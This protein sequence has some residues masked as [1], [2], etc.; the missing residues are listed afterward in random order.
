MSIIFPP[1]YMSVSL[2][3]RLWPCLT[4]ALS[5]ATLHV[6]CDP[7]HLRNKEEAQYYHISCLC[8]DVCIL[9]IQAK[10]KSLLQ[11]CK[12]STIPD[13]VCR[14][15]NCLSHN[16]SSRIWSHHDGLYILYCYVLL[17]WLRLNV[18]YIMP[19]LNSYYYAG[20]YAVGDPWS[21]SGCQSNTDC[22][23]G[24]LRCTVKAL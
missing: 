3:W 13:A 17:C 6:K 9:Y 5:H 8:R 18:Y 7:N 15:V 19:S 2:H 12:L 10:L 24:F 22:L 1:L 14:Y 23:C 4:L 21:Y 16:S 20:I 11:Q